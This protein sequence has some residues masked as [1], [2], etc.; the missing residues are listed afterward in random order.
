MNAAGVGAPWMRS[1]LQGE[2]GRLAAFLRRDFL[3]AWSYRVPF[4]ADLFALAAQAVVFY[5]VSRMVDPGAIPR[6]GGMQ[7]SYMAFVAVG[8]ALNTLLQIGIG[9]MAVALRGEQLMGTLASL[10]V[11]P[12]SAM[13]LQL[14]LVVY[15]LAYVP[16][17]TAVFLVM[18]DVLFGVDFNLHG[19]G[20]AVAVLVA[21]MPFVWGLGAASAAAVLTLRRVPGVLGFGAALLGVASG[22]YFPLEL[23]PSWLAA[24]ARLN[25]V[26]IALHAAREALLGSGGWAQV[27][28]SLLVLVPSAML[29]LV[30]GSLA[31]HLALQRERR[32]GTL[33]LY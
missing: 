32:L 5:F 10:M 1:G 25:P 15:D 28:P 18:I 21:F 6:F 11:T 2:I 7:T 19:L 4:I 24:V 14:G 13:T 30:A 27:G 23:L 22:A 9:Q 16:V 33:G 31:Y 20:P 8:I 3:V 29:T 26:A 12:T 17:R